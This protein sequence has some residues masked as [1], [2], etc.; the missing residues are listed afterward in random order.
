MK[1]IRECDGKPWCKWCPEKTTRAVWRSTGLSLNK[2]SCEQHK[3]D[4]EEYE[5]QRKGNGYMSEA[6]YQTWGRL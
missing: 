6:D 5:N 3:Q 1:K 2:H 4:L